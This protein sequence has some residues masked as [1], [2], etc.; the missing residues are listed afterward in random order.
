VIDSDGAQLGILSPKEAIQIAERKGLDLLEI[1]PNVNPPVCK[2]IDF[3]KYKYELQKKEKLQKKNQIVILLKEV[4]FHPNT[5]EH[6]FEFKARHAR[7]FITEGHKVKAVVIFKGREITY[8]EYGANV[9][10][11]LTERLSDIAK[12]DQPAHMEGKSMII[13]YSPDKTK[14]KIESKTETKKIEEK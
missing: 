11:R 5:D 7:N 10:D 2:I 13:I 4:R 14:K 6:D 12:V 9:I 8:Q 3:G 1:V